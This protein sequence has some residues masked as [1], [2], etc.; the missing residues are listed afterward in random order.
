MLHLLR[1]HGLRS[2]RSGLC[3]FVPVEI[4]KLP[5]VLFVA[6][7]ANKRKRS[8]VASGSAA[9]E[10]NGHVSE[11]MTNPNKNAEVLDAP[12]AL[13]ASPDSDV[14]EDIVPGRVKLEDASDSSL[15]DV[16][17]VEPPKKKQKGGKKK[18]SATKT[19]G[20]APTTPAT[21]ASSA[22]P[23]AKTGENDTYDPE[24]E[25][26]GDEGV[27]EE[28]VKEALLRP[29]PVNSGYL[30]LPWKGRLG[31]ACLCTYL[32]FSNPPIFSS[33]TCRIQSILEHRHPLQDP[34]Q[35]EHP[36]KNR[37]DKQKPAD[38]ALGKRY[39][40]ELCL[41]N[42]RDIAKMI[43]WNDKY[44]IKFLRLSSEMFPFASHEEYGY[45]LA[46]F[47]SEALAEAGKVI[48]ELG[49]RVTT[50]PGQVSSPVMRAFA[51]TADSS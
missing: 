25:G 46:P 30:P 37:P 12:D 43:R 3:S 48:A 11:V 23:K 17:E 39:V 6:D 19:N 22:K 31:Y 4:F 44:G 14:N 33:R 35:P 2:I 26:E 28:E 8:S 32:R 42:V 50:H 27:T 41:A 16:P 36:I 40:E 24:G 10:T 29:P 34:S 1:R 7:M 38:E 45:K 49:H 20:T 5:R 47:A 15:S 18:D 13:R 51:S 21:P 9:T